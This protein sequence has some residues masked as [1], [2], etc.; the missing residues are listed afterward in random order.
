VSRLLKV[1]IIAG[2]ESG[3]LLGADLIAGLRKT[4]DVKLIGVGGP[5]LASLGLESL[6]NPTEIALMGV[7]AIVKTLPRLIGLI[8][9]TAS[10]IAHEKPDCLIIIDS[11][12]FCQRVAKKVRKSNPAIPIV[13]YVCPSVWAWRP[14]RAKTMKSYIDHILAI[15]PFE[16]QL[17]HDLG[18]PPATYVGHPAGQNEKFLE[19]TAAQANLEEARGAGGEKQ[20]LI[21]PGSR[22]GEIGRS[23]PHMAEAVQILKTRGH[24]LNLLLPTLPHLEAHVR[25]L[26]A[27]WVVAPQITTDAAQ[28]HIMFAKADAALAASGTVTLELALCT[29]PTVAIYDLDWMARIIV[30][31]MY[32]AWTASL[33]NII[34][35]EPVV[36]EYYNDQIRSAMLARQIERIIKPGHARSAQREGFQ[37]MREKMAT[38]SPSGER[39][40]EAVLQVIQTKINSQMP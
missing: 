11:P 25:A 5:H 6:F 12:E 30:R 21:L 40:A 4:H 28:K 10:H 1:A 26:T 36:A 17:L 31:Y 27:N 35:D 3:D 32:K 29:V 34:A 2:E 19:A 23:L 37:R 8:R 38:H 33:P 20:L 13:N 24:S 16:P 39:A 7:T 18:G 15:L 14:G 22:R 9:K